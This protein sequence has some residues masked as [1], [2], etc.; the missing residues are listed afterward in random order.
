[1][2]IISHDQQ[3]TEE[4]R[5]GVLTR[6]RVSA[7]T[8]AVQLC[9][10]EQWCE[11]GTGAR[12]H[13]H[14]VEEVLTIVAGQAEFWVGEERQR[15]SAGQSVLVPAGLKHGFSNVGD[16]ILHLQAV[17]AAPYFEMSLEK[18]SEPTR[19]WAKSIGE[20]RE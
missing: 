15:V 3:P 17:L 5:A 2:R 9:I 11:P 1:M 16:S 12:T 10:F 6:M 20:Q 14:H 18:G 7:L 4:W 8:D 13:L 19:R